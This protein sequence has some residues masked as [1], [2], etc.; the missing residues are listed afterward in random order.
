MEQVHHETS[1]IIFFK[2]EN[3]EM[4]S[5]SFLRSFIMELGLG[6]TVL[7][8][9]LKMKQYQASPEHQVQSII[10]CLLLLVDTQES[11]NVNINI[12]LMRGE[13]LVASLVCLYNINILP[14]T[15]E[16]LLSC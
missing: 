9:I 3:E 2:S 5:E 14:Q 7:K 6:P 13:T 10:P 8:K 11:E 12:M 15:L 16:I 1:E 4:K